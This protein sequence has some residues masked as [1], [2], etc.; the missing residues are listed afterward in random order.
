[1]IHD[2][3]CNLKYYKYHFVQEFVILSINDAFIG[4]ML[5]KILLFS[6]A[7]CEGFSYL[8]LKKLSKFYIL[9]RCS[10]LACIVQL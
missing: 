1:M 5:W 7:L 9:S 2:D 3:T 4:R 6:L 8:I 10:I